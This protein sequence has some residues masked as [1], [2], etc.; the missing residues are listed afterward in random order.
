MVTMLRM[1]MIMMVLPMLMF[2]MINILISVT[3]VCV[4]DMRL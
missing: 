1:M 2:A 3:E 4:R